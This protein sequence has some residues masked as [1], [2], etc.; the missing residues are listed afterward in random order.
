MPFARSRYHVIFGYSAMKPFVPKERDYMERTEEDLIE[1]A[2][3]EVN[4]LLHLLDSPF[5]QCQ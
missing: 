5:D 4:N 1:K 3:T 2:P